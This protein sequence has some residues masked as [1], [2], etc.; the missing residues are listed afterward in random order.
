MAIEHLL[1]E[2]IT[3]VGKLKCGGLGEERTGDNGN[4]YRLPVRYDHWEITTLIRGADGRLTV[5]TDLMESLKPHCDASGKLTR[6]P[7]ACL[8]NDLSEILMARYVSYDGKRTQAA[9][10]GI[11]ITEY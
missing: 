10:D 6:I 7:I 3:E 1:R 4:K 11:T 8:S 9:S 2:S 5:D